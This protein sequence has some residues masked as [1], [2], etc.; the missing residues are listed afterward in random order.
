MITPDSIVAGLFFWHC[1]RDPEYL[2]ES[3]GILYLASPDEKTNMWGAF[4]FK[5]VMPTRQSILA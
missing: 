3:Y 1:S 4:G 2:L 5:E